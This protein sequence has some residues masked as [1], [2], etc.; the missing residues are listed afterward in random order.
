MLTRGFPTCKIQPCFKTLYACWMYESSF[1]EDEIN[2]F[3]MEFS[4]LLSRNIC[5]IPLV[6]EGWVALQS[7]SIP[8]VE[9]NA[10]EH[11]L[12][13]WKRVQE[14]SPYI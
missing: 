7:H 13:M 12:N 2:E 5:E 9:N 14:R 8:F 4:D 6:G 1:C 3:S 11:Y 10:E